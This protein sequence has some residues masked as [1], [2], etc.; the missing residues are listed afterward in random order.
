MLI[1]GPCLL[2]ISSA[3]FLMI[4][5][6][7]EKEDSAKWMKFLIYKLLR[8]IRTTMEYEILQIKKNKCILVMAWTSIK[9]P[10]VYLYIY[11]YIS[12][13]LA[14]IPILDLGVF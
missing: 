10:L 9:L 4:S 13:F 14:N 5:E 8:N 6:G 1:F 12:S 7:I 11:I 3:D 2:K